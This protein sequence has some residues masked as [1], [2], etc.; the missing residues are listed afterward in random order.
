MPHGTCP[1]GGATRGFR[2]AV[3]NQPPPAGR[4]SGVGSGMVRISAI[5]IAVCMVLIAASIG[6]ALYLRFGLT[7][8]ESGLVGL[9]ILTGLAVYNAI[10]A[11]LRDR[12]EAS[13][14]IST[15]SRSSG[16]LA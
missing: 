1:G 15:L 14:Q 9:G 10:S 2:D 4:N 6:I 3:A 5:F 13:D 12:V 16:D 11:R 8:A 7:G